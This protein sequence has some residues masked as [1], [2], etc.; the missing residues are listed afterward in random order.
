M[1]KEEQ[2]AEVAGHAS[3]PLTYGA[4][5]R[6]PELINLQ[7]LLSSPPAH[8]E[9]LFIITQQAQELW[10]KQVL[11]ELATVIENMNRG[12]LLEAVRFLGRVNRILKVL[13]EEVTVLETMPPQAFH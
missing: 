9:M 12:E 8:D 11:H 5:M 13:G 7:T 3:Q 1:L 10:F 2:G 4:Y 6:V